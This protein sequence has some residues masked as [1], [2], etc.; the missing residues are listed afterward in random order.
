MSDVETRVPLAASTIK[1]EDNAS[2]A[3]EPTHV[4]SDAL[5]LALS[6]GGVRAALFSL[7]VVIGLIETK[8]HRRVRCV[9][10]VSGGSILNS[11]LAHP[12]G[13]HSFSTVEEFE[14]LAKSL[15]TSLAWR[16]AFFVDWRSIPAGFWYLTRVVARALVP[17]L[18]LLGVLADMLENKW[19]IKLGD[20]DY[21]M[22]PWQTV[23]YIAVA[24]LL[25]SGLLSRGLFQE[26]RYASILRTV[27]AAS[28]EGTYQKLV[29]EWSLTSAKGGPGVMHVLVATD[30]LSGEPMYFSTQF[31]HCRPYGWSTPNNISTAEALYSSAAFPAVFPPKKLKL[32]RLKFQNGEMT[33]ALPSL[34]RL[35]DGGI[36]N[37]LG[38]DWFEV[39]DKQSEA[40]PPV[41]WPFGEIKV[42][43]L[44]IK[45]ENIIVIN[46]SAPSRR[47]QRLA[48]FPLSLSR[49]MSVLYDNTVKPRLLAISDKGHPLIDIAESPLKLAR[50]LEKLDGE[51]GL[52]AKSIATTL[53]GR[54]D[55]FWAD[56]SRDTAGTKTKLSGAGR[57]TGA[58]LM[59]DGYLLS[60]VL[61][62]VIFKAKL[63]EKIKGEEYFLSLVYGDQ[64]RSAGRETAAAESALVEPAQPGTPI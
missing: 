30:L 54:D 10:S 44:K 47:V 56:F 29:K 35:A 40:S 11:A 9:A 38:T 12:P 24:S 31:V 55:V 63:P 21:S 32:K 39:L 28:A 57:R 4:E 36:Y 33:G 43:P 48:P 27:A 34:V 61:L 1:L 5:G 58:R 49:I 15:A 7:G 26:A 18:F 53:K 16:G 51:A 22:V 41:L 45:T 19:N 2:A 25:V 3:P 8:C 20:L 23:G 14:P 52:R 17:L 37:N 62:H 50:R 6:G 59:L 42:N 64:N 60:L 13:L 46:A